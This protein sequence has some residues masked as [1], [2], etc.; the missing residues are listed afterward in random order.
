MLFPPGWCT[1]VSL[2]FLV[3][4]PAMALL[5]PLD[6][7]NFVA[8]FWYYFVMLYLAF[9]GLALPL[10]LVSTSFK[11]KKFKNFSLSLQLSIFY[12][13]GRSFALNIINRISEN[14]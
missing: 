1:A 9:I 7:R 11:K 4:Y 5:E 8:H 13:S 3:T 6:V 10:V 2:P 12:V 14:E